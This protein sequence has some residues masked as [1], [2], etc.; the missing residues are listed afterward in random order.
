MAPVATPSLIVAIVAPGSVKTT[1]YYNP[2]SPP[3]VALV[4]DVPAYTAENPD[5]FPI[6]R[7]IYN[8]T[9]R[10]PNSNSFIFET[11]ILNFVV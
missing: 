11:Q 4:S 7:H 10:S 1:P 8:S 2:D 5:A 6:V 9:S 3:G